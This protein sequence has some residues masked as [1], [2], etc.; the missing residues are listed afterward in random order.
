MKHCTK[1]KLLPGTSLTMADFRRLV[2]NFQMGL[3]T[4]MNS[5]RYLSLTVMI[6]E[7]LTA[8]HALSKPSCQLSLLFGTCS[9][10]VQPFMLM[11]RCDSN[12]PCHETL[13]LFHNDLA[14]RTEKFQCSATLHSTISISSILIYSNCKQTVTLECG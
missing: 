4:F 6:T 7:F 3:A 10:R 9:C 1:L 11:L 8:K 5:L 2:L 12:C 14:N 13:F